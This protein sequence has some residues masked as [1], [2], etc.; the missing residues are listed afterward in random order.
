MEIIEAG[1]KKQAKKIGRSCPI[2]KDKQKA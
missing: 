2:V 1:N